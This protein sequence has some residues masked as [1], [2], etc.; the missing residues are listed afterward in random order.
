MLQYLDLLTTRRYA[1]ATLIAIVKTLAGL[2]RALPPERQGI[3]AEDITQT[4]AHDISAFL[5]TGLT[6]G[7]APWG[8]ATFASGCLCQSPLEHGGDGSNRHWQP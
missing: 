5:R 6:A 2:L 3:L 4:T 7:L 1:P 8:V